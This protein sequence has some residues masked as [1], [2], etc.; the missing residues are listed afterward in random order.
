MSIVIPLPEDLK[1]LE[2]PIRTV[3]E[4][5]EQQQ[6]LLAKE[7]TGVD[8]LE[9]ESQVAKAVSE[10][11]RG[12]HAELLAALV[13]DAR[14]ITVDGRVYRRAVSSRGTYYTRAGPV[15]FQRPLYRAERNGPTVDPVALRTGAIRGG[16]LP[17]TAMAMAH[18]LQLG[19]SREAETAAKQLQCL[20]YSRSAF[21]DVGHDVGAAYRADRTD[22]DDA[23]IA[24]YEVPREARSL[25]A[26]LDRVSVPV[27]VERPRPVGRPRKDA[28][29]RPMEV[30]YRMAYA[31]TLTLHDA[32]GRALRTLRYG[33]APGEDA[34]ALLERALAD[35]V[36][37]RQKCPRL[38]VVLLADGAPEMWRLLRTTFSP[39][40][41][42]KRKVYEVLD[43][44]HL[45]E[46]LAAAAKVVFGAEADAMMRRW[47]CSVLNTTSAATRILNTLRC[48]GK[49][50]VLV[51]EQRPVHDAITYLENHS[52]L[53][54]Y[55]EAR[56]LGLPIGSGM[57]E[58]TCKSLFAQ[59]LKRSGARW[60][61]KGAG[62]IIDLRAMALSGRWDFGVNM[63]F[64][65]RRKEVRLAA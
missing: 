15:S 43:F 42:G 39:K 33:A 2:A 53:L 41:L 8:Y 31:G 54:N 48:S 24:Q 55:V 61:E 63:L 21:E 26:C 13:V 7:A 10:I 49:R 37:L 46:K 36:M 45:V 25:S 65:R 29:K 4:I 50:D 34:S 19:T 16:W 28:P 51:G 6:A 11:E 47:R 58:A 64:E 60:S 17:G 23:W 22:I 62:E 56:S 12:V 1:A 32:E 59:R 30:V 52:E 38:R 35:A 5:A 40:L 57:V 3:I 20:P 44:F 14:E 27:A 18:L 9:I